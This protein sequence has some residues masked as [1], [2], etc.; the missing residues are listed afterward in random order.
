[1]GLNMHLARHEMTDQDFAAMVSE[2]AGVD[3][4]A[5][6]IAGWRRDG[7]PSRFF[8]ITGPIGL[9][10]TGVDAVAYLLQVGPPPHISCPTCSCGLGPDEQRSVAEAFLDGGSDAGS[11]KLAELRSGVASDCG[12]DTQA[13]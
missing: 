4:T 13:G 5:D 11:D 1:M 10:L 7:F 3:W 12:L 2:E 8:D 9:G 6:T